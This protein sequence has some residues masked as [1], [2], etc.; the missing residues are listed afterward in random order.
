MARII[1]EVMP[2]PEI[3]DPQGKAVQG[4][5]PHQGITAFS[6]VR[7]G[8]RFELE[9]DGPITEEILDEAEK[10][11]TTVLS[12]PIIEDV[13]DIYGVLDDGDAC[14]CGCGSTIDNSKPD[15]SIEQAGCGCGSGES[16]CGCTSQAPAPEMISLTSLN[17]PE[18]Q[19]G[20]GCGGH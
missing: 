3:L 5:L 13:V 15:E 9:V 19:G 17:A 2:K 18:T 12:N 10:A 14:G 11:A 16:G 8:K 20:C 1:I 6:Q 7:Q 4:A